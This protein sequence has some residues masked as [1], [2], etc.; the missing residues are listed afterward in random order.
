MKK[1]NN[2][3]TEN[4]TYKTMN[5]NTKMKKQNKKVVGY[6]ASTKGNVIIQFCR[7]TN[8][9]IPY[10]VERNPEK[11]GRYT[12]GSFIPIISEKRSRALNPD[13]FLV[14]PWHFKKEIV[15]REKLFL[16]KGGKLIFPLPNI[17]MVGKK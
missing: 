3:E 12:P 14:M 11:F 15:S 8:K 1:N 2:K 4:L 17:R 5:E 13:F 9:M 7:L 10:A 16:N 6:G